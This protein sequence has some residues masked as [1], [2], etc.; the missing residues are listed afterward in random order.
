MINGMMIIN[1]TGNLVNLHKG[2]VSDK[3]QQLL[4]TL[5]VY[6]HQFM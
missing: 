4:N 2:G 5:K 1:I 3:I 6:L